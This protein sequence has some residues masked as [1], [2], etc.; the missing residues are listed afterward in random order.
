MADL[1]RDSNR[2][3]WFD[4]YSIR[5]QTANLQG[6]KLNSPNK[7]RCFLMQKAQYRA[8]NTL[9]LQHTEISSLHHE[10][11]TVRQS[12]SDCT[13]VWVCALEVSRRWEFLWE[14]HYV[15]C[16]NGN[17]NKLMGMGGNGNDCFSKIFPYS[18]IAHIALS[19]PHYAYFR[20]ADIRTCM[21]IAQCSLHPI[22][23]N[24]RLSSQLFGP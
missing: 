1:I 17:G 11:N 14:W 22:L 21:H 4:S 20:A 6:P 15:P 24:V 5:T 23:T 7:A 16:A 13:D 18:C 2:N 8:T 10:N 12:N 19:V 3:A 9:A